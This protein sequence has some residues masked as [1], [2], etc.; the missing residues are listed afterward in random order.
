MKTRVRTFH[1]SSLF[2]CDNVVVDCRMV[3]LVE[4]LDEKYRE[5]E[6]DN[7][8]FAFI[9]FVLMCYLFHHS[10][11]DGQSRSASWRAQM[12]MKT[13]I[14]TLH[15]SSLSGSELCIDHL[16]SLVTVSL[17]IAGW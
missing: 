7:Q 8:N 13:R 17:L 6:D 14:R 16:C 15:L 5:D 12:R 11:Q 2:S 4:S 9:V 10:L 1:L 3:S